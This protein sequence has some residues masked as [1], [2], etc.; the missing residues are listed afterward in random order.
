MHIVDSRHKTGMEDT[1]RLIFE[2]LRVKDDDATYGLRASKIFDSYPND[3]KEIFNRLKLTAKDLPDISLHSSFNGQYELVVAAGVNQE[4]SDEKMLV[5]DYLAKLTPS[6]VPLF[7]GALT[8]SAFTSGHK[9]W[10]Y[11]LAAFAVAVNGLIGMYRSG[12]EIIKDGDWEFT[13]AYP[14]AEDLKKL[15]LK[16]RDEKV[17]VQRLAAIVVTT[18][19]IW[20]NTNHHI[21]G[22]GLPPIFKYLGFSDVSG[23]SRLHTAI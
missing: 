17:K 5:P 2:F 12:E 21:G 18:K 3:L 19:I 7:V 20:W 14:S 9:E 4:L 8:M 10:D 16:V 1:K 23:V 11:A 22:D 6:L 15:S 13:S